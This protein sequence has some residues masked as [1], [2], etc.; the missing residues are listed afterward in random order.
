MFIDKYISDVL[1]LWLGR[2]STSIVFCFCP[3]LKVTWLRLSIDT[4][5]LRASDIKAIVFNWHLRWYLS[6]DRRVGMWAREPWQNINA[7]PRY[8]F[9]GAVCFS[10][11]L[12]R[13]I[14][15]NL[16]KVIIFFEIYTSLSDVKPM[17]WAVFAVVS[18]HKS[19][20]NSRD[21]LWP[22]LLMCHLKGSIV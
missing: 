1:L 21:E 9:S 22:V 4:N 10:W 14:I 7:L 6:F 17:V 13:C 15:R 12:V 16:P 5:S 2:I 11:E 18:T 19:V 8:W 20:L 3:V